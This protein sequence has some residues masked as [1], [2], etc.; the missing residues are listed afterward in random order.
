MVARR[1]IDLDPDCFCGGEVI[2]PNELADKLL[3]TQA[4][5]EY[6][7]LS[8]E[9]SQRYADIPGFYNTMIGVLAKAVSDYVRYRGAKNPKLR[10]LYREARLWLFDEYS[11]GTG[12]CLG[13]FAW[14]CRELDR[15]PAPA[16]ERIRKMRITDLPKVDRK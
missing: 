11:P 14:V 2:I 16:R 9:D 8:E 4:V 3:S 13:S 10:M 5:A 7:G 6:M 15:D 12:E 1:L